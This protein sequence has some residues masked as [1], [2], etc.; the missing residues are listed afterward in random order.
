[1]SE[2]EAADAVLPTAAH[3]NCEVVEDE[4]SGALFLVARHAIRSG[5]FLSVAADSS[6]DDDDDDD[7]DDE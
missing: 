5:E 1:M 7:D 4:E 6:D 2:A 3:P